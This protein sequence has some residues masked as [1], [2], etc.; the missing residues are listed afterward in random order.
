MR[1]SS[2]VGALLIANMLMATRLTLTLPFSSSIPP[3]LNRTYRS[4]SH[5]KQFPK[6]HPCPLWSSS[7]SFC[8]HTLR[9]STSPL[10]ASSSLSTPSMAASSLDEGNPLLQNFVFPPFDVVEPKHVRPGIR[11][12]LGKL[13]HELEELE[14]SVEPSWPKLVEPLEKIIDQL[15]VV[16][17]MVNHLKA[18]KDSSELR[19]AIE[20]VQA[21]KVKFQLRLGQS[22]P[23]Y[24]AFKAIQESPNWQT[25]SDARKR[26]VESQI[27]EA[28]LNGVSLEDDKRESFNKIE[29]E[30]EK[31]SQ[32]FG[33]NVLDATKKF[34]KLITDKTEIEGLPATALG[35]AAQ[36][37]VSKGHENATAENGPWIITLDAPSFIAVMQ[38]ARNRSLRE[39]IYRAYVSRASSGDLDN[40]GIID[41]IL[42]LRLEKAKLLN[43]NNYAEVSM[44][45]KMATV[46]KAEE[47]LEKLRR[48][49]W[50]AAVQ[51]I[52]DLKEFSK[53]QGALEAGDLTHW[54]I[55]YW[56]ERL[57]ESKYDINEEELRPFFSLPKVMD[58]LFNLAKSLFGIEIEPADGLAPV[59]N[60]DVR[61]FCVKDSSGSPIAYFYFDPYSRPAEKRQGA[62]MNEVFA[63]SRVLSRDGTSARLPVAH[64]VCNQTPPVGNKPSLM[65]FREVETVFHEFGHALQH[66]LTK[67]DEGL[68]AGIRGIE[69]DAVELPSQF[70]ENWCYHRET[71]MGIAK[72]FETGESL[73]E[74]VYL[75]LVAA[76]TF[77]AGSLSLR[78]L[79]F[80]S[81]D[82]ELHT[83]YVPGGPESIYDVDHRVSE[84]TQVIPPLPEDRFLC[85]F[86]HIF[87]GGYAAG[88]YSYKW[89]EVLSADAFSAFE[90]AGL[91]NDKAV[92]ET[93]RKFRETI[94]ALGGGKPPLDVF[95]QFR[96]RE[97]TPDAL[98]R[99]NGLLQVAAS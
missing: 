51:D 84:K 65:T 25:L 93:G 59:W 66:M 50:D 39:E 92:K 60:N 55:T 38:H 52:E 26:I 17:G 48:S 47:L 43:Y 61:F 18:V 33:E 36:S 44:A 11:A 42:K 94:L 75:K 40:T 62:W 91:D 69:W 89:A 27:K 63:R 7:F 98:L 64:M 20:D 74:E 49:S 95:V 29:Q 4:L 24:N 72:H 3:L 88:Y 21:E 87:A 46:D 86:S 76:R 83:K 23:I 78:Q 53:S 30:L 79:K 80:A 58:G 14:R 96:G 19:S 57:R 13:E 15:S 10:R 32:K 12:L 35:L 9:K 34:E 99:H 85:S 82:L 67:Q 90:D 81:V 37:A 45:T 68:V 71:L 73:P 54:D 70:M 6:S 97:P 1:R 31:L 77:R 22:K 41:Q 56:S 5:L 28:V 8:L 16:W 2:L